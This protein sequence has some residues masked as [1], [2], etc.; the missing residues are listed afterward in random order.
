[1]IFEL[2]KEYI[3]TVLKQE[4]SF[5]MQCYPERS[6]EFLCRRTHFEILHYVQDNVMLKSIH[7]RSFIIKRSVVLVCRLFISCSFFPVCKHEYTVIISVVTIILT[8]LC[9]G[10]GRDG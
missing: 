4:I 2:Y 1:M 5:K 6:E 8:K 10:V 9:T 7:S 3:E